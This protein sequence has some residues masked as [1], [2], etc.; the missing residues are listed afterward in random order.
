MYAPRSKFNSGNGK[1][2]GQDAFP[3]YM[4]LTSNHRL[5]LSLIC[6]KRSC[7]VAYEHRKDPIQGSSS[8]VLIRAAV[9]LFVLLVCSRVIVIKYFQNCLDM[10]EIRLLRLVNGVFHAEFIRCL[11]EFLVSLSA[12]GYCSRKVLWLDLVGR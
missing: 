7:P 4:S 12:C 3:T 6:A 5:Y 1:V 10:L 8:C 11:G 2:Q 9:L